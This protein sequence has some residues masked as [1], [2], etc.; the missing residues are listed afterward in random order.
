MKLRARD[1]HKFTLKGLELDVK[2]GEI[3]TLL[4][5]SGSGKTTL[6]RMISG[7]ERPD[8]G[9]LELDGR[10]VFERGRMV[11]PEERGVGI[12]FQ[13][14]CLFP[15]LDVAQNIS[16]G[17]SKLK[18]S[19]ARDRTADMIDH[20]GLKGFEKSYPHQLSGG[21]QQRVALAR[22]MVMEPSLI[23]LDEPFSNL[24][25]HLRE[26]VRSEFVKLLRSR[27]ETAIVVTHDKKDALSVSDRIALLH[28][29]VIEQ[30]DAPEV[31]YTRPATPYVANYFGRTN[32]VDA[33]AVSEGFETE[34]G[35]IPAQH[36]EPS[37]KE[38]KI[39]IRPHWCYVTDTKPLVKG[40]VNEVIE[41]GECKEVSLSIRE[42]MNFYIHLHRHEQVEE[43]QELSVAVEAPSLSLI[44]QFRELTKKA[45]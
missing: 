26:S 28:D 27:N 15:N 14:F 5:A 34:F 41:F 45:E 6:L 18:R 29:G 13:N 30:V 7:V 4:G 22:T 37:G 12:V 36:Q 11:P 23:L 43:D 8:R 40:R 2:E 1:I 31:I 16:F 42:G 44:E 25:E 21:Q 35:V 32:L 9:T 20:F 33:K 3:L 10:M 19:E 24:D 39:S 17:L 38:G